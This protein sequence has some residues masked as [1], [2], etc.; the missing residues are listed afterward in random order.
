MGI[1]KLSAAFSIRLPENVGARKNS[2][3]GKRKS[4]KFHPSFDSLRKSPEA[5]F[6]RNETYKSHGTYKSHSWWA[7]AMRG[8]EFAIPQYV[9]AEG[10]KPFAHCWG[11]KRSEAKRRIP[12]RAH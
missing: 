4:F 11:F 2:F 8:L 7:G 6:M 1:D 9:P 10:N 3:P 12:I 5:P